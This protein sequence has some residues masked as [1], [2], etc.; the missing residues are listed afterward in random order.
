MVL[1][2]IVKLKLIELFVSVHLAYKATPWWHVL[3]LAVHLI[4]NVQTTKNVI[5]SL[6]HQTERNVNHFVGTIHVHLVLLVVHQIT[7]KYVPA[8][9]HFKEMDMYPVQNVSSI[10][11]S[12][13]F[14]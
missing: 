2:Q 6:H 12:N 3:R 13:L 9:I 1:G 11:L 7:E 5:T 10:L 4:L 14:N 8:I